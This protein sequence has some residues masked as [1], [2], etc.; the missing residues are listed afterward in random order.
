[1]HG[2]SLLRCSEI[3]YG[4]VAF[5]CLGCCSVLCGDCI[6]QTTIYTQYFYWGNG[7]K[8]KAIIRNTQ[9]TFLPKM[10]E[11]SKKGQ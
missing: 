8:I 11:P 5:A 9:A 2:G 1:M 4:T 10:Q 6:T 3:F 7:G